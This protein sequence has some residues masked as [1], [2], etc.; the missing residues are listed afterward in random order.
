[1]RLLRSMERILCIQ[2]KTPYSRIAGA[3]FVFQLL[4]AIGFAWCIYRIIVDGANMVDI[5]SAGASLYGFKVLAPSLL[6]N[7]EDEGGYN[8]PN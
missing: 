7:I 3:R 4:F 8:V 1:M 2:Y 6:K 5:V